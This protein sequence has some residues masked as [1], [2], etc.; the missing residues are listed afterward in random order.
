MSAAL[1]VP[2]V[3]E[4]VPGFAQEERNA[5]APDFDAM[6]APH[7]RKLRPYEA[8]KP[9]EEVQRELGLTDIVKLASNEN[10]FGPS[11]RVLEALAAAVHRSDRLFL[12]PDAAV[13]ETRGA[14]AA[15]LGID[16]QWVVVGNGSNEI[17]ALVVRT[18]LQP[19]ENVV[20]SLGTFPAYGLLAR[21]HG[22]ELREAPLGPGF[23]YDLQAVAHFVDRNTRVVFLANPNNPTGT[24]FGHAALTAFLA[25]I[26][27]QA[28]PAR[29]P[30]VVLDEAY[31]EYLDRETYGGDTL[32]LVRA[33]PT[34]IVARTFSKAFALAGLRIGY[35]VMHPALAAF[36][37]RVR[38]PFNVNAL[39]QVAARAALEDLVWTRAHVAIA[40]SERTRVMGEL[41]TLGLT[42]VPSEAN[43][44]FIDL[45]RPGVP[46][47]QALLRRGVIAR[48]TAAG[49]L[50]DGLR[51][52]IGR[53]D[54]NTRFLEALSA[55]LH[56]ETIAR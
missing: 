45:G 21:A 36:V 7:I 47:F 31:F 14:I 32:A 51:V 39:A 27:A 17:L 11:P 2:Q 3:A 55:V 13:A 12:Y 33:R 29:P 22:A 25:A 6:V 54:E 37:S 26:D 40:C 23:A 49:G 41:T 30:I 44:V 42:V 15:F 48:P 56:E 53:P 18:F 46:I 34:T 20:T 38:E 52:T 43:F 8:G 50:P 35:G 9:I 1:A 5:L 10:P 19:G 4:S 16:P 24:A 28:D